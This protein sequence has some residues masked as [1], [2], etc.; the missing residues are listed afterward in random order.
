MK[1]LSDGAQY[2]PRN[3]AAAGMSAWRVYLRLVRYAW[4]Y[5]ARLAVSLVFAMLVAVSFGS[6]DEPGNG[7]GEDLSIFMN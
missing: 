6:R 2:E 3:A 4:R 5:K 7:A 1:T